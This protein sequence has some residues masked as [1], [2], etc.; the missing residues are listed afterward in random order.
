MDERQ[1]EEIGKRL[2]DL[3]KRLLVVQGLA[4]VTLGFLLAVAIGRL[5]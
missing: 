5:L 4:A 1:F 3:K 2:D